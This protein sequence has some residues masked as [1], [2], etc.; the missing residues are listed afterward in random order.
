V[1]S[2]VICDQSIHSSALLEFLIRGPDA[3][4]P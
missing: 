2:I 4:G 1:I 3:E